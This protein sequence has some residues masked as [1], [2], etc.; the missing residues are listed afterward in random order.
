MFYC[1]SVVQEIRYF[2]E[3]IHAFLIKVFPCAKFVMNYRTD[4]EKQ[5]TSGFFKAKENSPAALKKKTDSLIY[6]AKKYPD[7][8]FLMPMDTFSD[9][10]KWNSLFSFLGKKNCKASGVA[11]YNNSSSYT[12]RG[13]YTSPKV[14]SCS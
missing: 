4:F 10:D 8:T 1:F 9:L 6:F 5:A 7:K 2:N 14:V 3:D 11:I 13:E 12:K